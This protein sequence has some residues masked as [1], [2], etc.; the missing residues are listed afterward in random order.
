M[1]FSHSLVKSKASTKEP[2]DLKIFRSR[3]KE[4]PCLV[5]LKC[6]LMVGILNSAPLLLPGRHMMNAGLMAA[7][8]GGM[9]P[10]ML[11]SS[12]NTGMGCLI[13]VSG[14]STVM[15]SSGNFKDNSFKSLKN[16]RQ[17][18]ELRFKSKKLLKGNFKK[19]T[20]KSGN[21]KGHK[22]VFFSYVEP[23]FH[24][25][26]T[27]KCNRVCLSINKGCFSRVPHITKY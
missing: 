17:E 3:E 18:L 4:K 13:G 7:S 16:H 2:R 14:L 6:F 21:P 5:F 25:S 20:S 19:G 26:L 27:E 9:V 15:V 12:Y 23:G 1:R 10:F 11:S 8:M 24:F 22:T